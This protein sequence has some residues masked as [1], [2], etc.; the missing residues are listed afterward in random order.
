M[1]QLIGNALIVLTY[2]RILLGV[3]ILSQN[4]LLGFGATI[5]VL[6][7]VAFWEKKSPT[8]GKKRLLRG[9]AVFFATIVVDVIVYV[10]F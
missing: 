7:L 9:L 4:I 5:A 1:S 6:F 8:Q 10:L 2:I 3:S